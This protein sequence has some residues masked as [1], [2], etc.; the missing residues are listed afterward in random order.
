MGRL[1]VFKSYSCLCFS[2]LLQSRTMVVDSS[3]FFCIKT[4]YDY[5]RELV[6]AQTESQVVGCCVT[7]G[8]GVFFVPFAPKVC[9]RWFLQNSCSPRWQV[10]LG[11]ECFRKIGDI[12][13]RKKE[14]K[15]IYSVTHWL[16][17]SAYLKLILH[18]VEIVAF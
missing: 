4:K 11:S 18:I 14:K 8:V 9:H 5:Q 2:S 15:W 1:K 13:K 12:R 6:H 16:I 17:V 10:E 3:V 7:V